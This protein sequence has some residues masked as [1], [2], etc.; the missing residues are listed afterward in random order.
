MMT[1]TNHKV[2]KII[3]KYFALVSLNQKQFSLIKAFSESNL[4]TL[5]S[6]LCELQLDKTNK[7]ICAPSEDS[8]PLNPI[9]LRYALNG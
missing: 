5:E 9:S 7:M 3:R 8:Y 1:E 2:I 6:L 4:S